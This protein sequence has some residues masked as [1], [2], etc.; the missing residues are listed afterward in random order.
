[1]ICSKYEICGLLGSGGFGSTYKAIDVSDGDV[2]VAIKIVSLRGLKNWKQLE[3]FDREAQILQNLQHEAIPKYIDYFE[4]DT[5]DDKKFYLV[6]QLAPGTPLTRRVE[7]GWRP[8]ESEIEQ[9]AI[10]ILDV[11]DYMSSLRPP[12]IHR[13]LK[14]DNIIFDKDT[15]KAFVVDFG[16]VQ[17]VAAKMNTYV[18][19]S[20]IIGTFGYAAPRTIQR[21]CRNSF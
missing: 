9:I 15:N 11:L 6:Q 12:V 21:L 14:P 1:M 16:G 7:E 19:G 18:G 20:T 10:Q 17:A 5:V 8:T 3:L 2:E 4:I 13:D